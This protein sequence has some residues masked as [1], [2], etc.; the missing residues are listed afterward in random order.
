M[1]VEPLLLKNLVHLNLCYVSVTVRF[2][3]DLLEPCSASLERLFLC[4]IS[5]ANEDDDEDGYAVMSWL[6]ALAEL[7]FPRLEQLDLSRTTCTE[8][9][10]EKLVTGLPALRELFLVKLK[11][12]FVLESNPQS[13]WCAFVP[14]VP[15]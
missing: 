12:K 9:E 2:L 5:T 4:G 8:R 3:R 10:M 11:P 13:V 15:L 14:P 7:R 1:G 6:G